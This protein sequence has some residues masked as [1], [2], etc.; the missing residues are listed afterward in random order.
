LPS[1]GTAMYSGTKAFLDAFTTAVYRETRGTGVEISLVRPGAVKTDFFSTSEQKENGRRNPA[2][3]TGVS[4]DYTVGR[5]WRLIQRPRRVM[6]IPT[7]AGL[8]PL[9]EFAT[10]WIQ[11]LI[12]PVHLRSNAK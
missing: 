9:F 5:I 6:H 8:A 10:G 1:Q 4:V 2:T 3:G 7:L 11:D 12:G